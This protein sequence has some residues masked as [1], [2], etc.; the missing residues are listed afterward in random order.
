[1]AR[2]WR[3]LWPRVG[4]RRQSW[5]VGFY[6]HDRV[7]RSRSFSSAELALGWMALYEAAEREGPDS[8]RR[9]MLEQ[10]IDTAR[11]RPTG[12]RTI[13][14]VI[15]LYLALDADPSLA[16]GLAPATFEGYRNVASC[17]ILGAPM[18]N[19]RH[20]V[21]GSASYAVALARRPAN[22]FN[23]PEAPRRWRSEMRAAGVAA[24]TTH[25]AWQ[26]LS[27][28]LS[29]AARSH[30]VP[31]ITTNGCLLANEGAGARRRSERRGGT[32]IP[33]P[34]RRHGSQTPSWALSPHA[35][36]ATR[37][38]LLARR[39]QRDPILAQRDAIIASLQYGLATRSQETFAI[40]WRAIGATF[41]EIVEVI[42]YGHL[43]QWGKTPASIPRRTT[44]P[45]LLA[46]DLQAWR[47]AL[48]SWGHP[49]REEDFIIPGDLGRPGLGVRDPRTAAVHLSRNQI[50]QWGP[51]YFAP[52]LAQA[53]RSPGLTDILGATPYAM[54]R[55]GISL[56]LRAEDPQTVATECGTSIEMLQRHYAFA[57]DDL[58]RTGPRPADTEWRA[59]RQATQPRP[60]P[61]H[62]STSSPT[63]A[64]PP[65]RP[66]HANPSR[67]RPPAPTR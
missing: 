34:G 40:R 49:A 29:W 4:K 57:L 60:H 32:G 65:S 31:E 41:A 11:R 35:L 50:T 15:E 9:L 37:A 54:R 30:H 26:V 17:H 53:A 61:N 39:A 52:A 10:R 67:I 55:G 28:S 6:D 51:K 22:A 13:A 8:L 25:R 58:R 20:Q 63:G 64:V 3:K 46:E 66:I 16:G 42:A 19:H 45:S 36:E 5:I 7:E 38:A 1:V 27:A 59:A 21:I 14:E 43:E 62:S 12:T 48:R 44:L 56:R 47:D 23:G 2:P 24:P 33:A 18:H